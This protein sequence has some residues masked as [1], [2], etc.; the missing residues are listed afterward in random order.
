M[1]AIAFDLVTVPRNSIVVVHAEPDNWEAIANACR[2]WTNPL[3]QGVP[4]LFLQPGES[5]HVWSEEHLQSLGWVKIA[6]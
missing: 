3:F 1:S 2:E 4:V 5:F 6:R